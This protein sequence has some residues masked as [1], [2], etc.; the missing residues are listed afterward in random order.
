MTIWTLKQRSMTICWLA[1]T[2]LVVR[3][4]AEL[5]WMPHKEIRV[6]LTSA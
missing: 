6:Y 5:E 1:A 3:R 4:T 2:Y